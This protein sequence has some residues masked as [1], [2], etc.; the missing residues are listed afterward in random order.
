MIRRIVLFLVGFVFGGLLFVIGAGISQP[1]P[2]KC[3]HCA[4]LSPSVHDPHCTEAVQ[5]GWVCEGP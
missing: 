1:A 5:G 3:P 4:V 2:P